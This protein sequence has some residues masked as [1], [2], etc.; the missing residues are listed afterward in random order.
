MRDYKNV[1]VPKS[2]RNTSNRITVKRVDVGR[3]NAHTGKRIAGIGG[4]LLNVAAVLT[5][6][7]AGFLGWQVYQGVLHADALV[8]SGVDV[9]GVR[10]LTEADLKDIVG[11]F[12]G[13]NIFRV[14]LEAA[15]RRAR[16]NPWVRE[17]RIH[18]SLP[19]R[20]TMVFVERTPAMVLDTG[21]ARYLLDDEGVI[22]ERLVKEQALAWPLPVVAIKDYQ[23][24]PGDQVTSEGM[25]EA[26][27]LLAEISARGGWQLANVTIKANSPDSL[28]VVYADHE[29]KL[30][31]GRYAEKL[32][33]LAE[34]LADVQQRGIEIAYVDL[35]PERQA[36]AMVKKG[37]VQGPGAGVRKK[38]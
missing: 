34:V 36:A 18:R 10:Q 1:K 16:A 2:Y 22:I 35:R 13:Q 21:S 29:F 30:G 7:G 17:V 9:K 33:R 31:S 23:G 37:R 3:S 20:I 26:M 14:D 8:V 4:L 25:A 6:A 38:H 19:N 12:T 27:Q 32:R 24:H 28:S 5:F 15:A 11:A